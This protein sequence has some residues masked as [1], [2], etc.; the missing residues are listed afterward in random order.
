MFDHVIILCGVIYFDIKH[1]IGVVIHMMKRTFK[2]EATPDGLGSAT[3]VIL[4]K[5]NIG[6]SP[7]DTLCSIQISA[8]G[9]DT[10]DYNVKFL[11]VD[12]FDYVDFELAVSQTSSVLMTQ[13]FLVDAVKIEFNNLGVN[14]V[15]KVAVTFIQKGL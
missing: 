15:P 4:D 11:P 6:F 1:R 7:S 12:G 2:L 10:G 9:L 13:G 14:A 5:S 8:F 3:D